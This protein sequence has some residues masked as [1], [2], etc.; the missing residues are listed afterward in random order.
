MKG[1]QHQLPKEDNQS[2]LFLVRSQCKPKQHIRSDR[3]TYNI[4]HISHIRMELV[5]SY[6]ITLP[7]EVKTMRRDVAEAET[8]ISKFIKVQLFK[9]R[10]LI[11][12]IY[13]AS[14]PFKQLIEI[15]GELTRL[16]NKRNKRSKQTFI[17]PCLLF[18]RLLLQPRQLT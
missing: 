3:E 14:T 6:P 11:R 10:R 17:T 1:R 7:V 4:D 8:Q 9:I 18:N 5:R 13:Y 2:W 15:Q 12:H 16:A